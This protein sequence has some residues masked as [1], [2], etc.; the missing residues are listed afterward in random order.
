MVNDMVVYNL[1]CSVEAMQALGEFLDAAEMTFSGNE[2][3]DTGCCEVTVYPDETEKN[4]TALEAR[5]VEIQRA[6]AEVLGEPVPEFVREIIRREDWAESWKHHFPVTRLSRRVVVKPHWEDYAPEPHDVVLEIDPGMSFGTGHHGTTKACV[7]F[8]DELAAQGIHGR[9]L[10]LGCGSGILS[11]AALRL[12]F[13]SVIAVDNDEQACIVA[14]E[15]L[16]SLNDPRWELV[17]SGVDA[18]PQGQTFPVVVANI[19]ASVLLE[20]AEAI[21]AHVSRP[22]GNLI[23]SGILDS[24]FGEVKHRYHALGFHLLESRRLDEWRSGLFQAGACGD[25]SMEENGRA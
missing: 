10:D 21:A 2:H 8:L 3:V 16:K 13:E 19:L 15:N 17:H 7:Q 1:K 18:F 14:R 22:N 20:H 25:G 23:L 11:M 9:V 4:L 12:G 6:V 24:Q 5:L